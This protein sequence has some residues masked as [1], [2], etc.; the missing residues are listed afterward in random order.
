MLCFKDIHWLYARIHIFTLIMETA[1]SYET[2]VDF[3]K[4]A[5]RQS[6]DDASYYVL[7]AE[8]LATDTEV[9][10]SIPGA[11]RFSD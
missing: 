2:F 6:S 7:L 4:T 11:T 9:S 8:F 5:W 10:G 3:H 1:V